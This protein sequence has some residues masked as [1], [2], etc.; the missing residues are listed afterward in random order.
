[1]SS[2]WKPGTRVRVRSSVHDGTAGMTGLIEAVSYA[3]EEEATSVLL[4]LGD[5]TAAASGAFFYDNELEAE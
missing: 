5:G 4:D 3:K 2:V 1:V